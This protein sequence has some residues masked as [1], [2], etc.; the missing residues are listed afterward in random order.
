MLHKRASAVLWPKGVEQGLG[1]KG[2][3]NCV[4]GDFLKLDFFFFFMYQNWTLDFF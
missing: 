1:M 3:N 4:S 2:T